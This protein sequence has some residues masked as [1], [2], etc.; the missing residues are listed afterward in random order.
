MIIPIKIE[1]KTFGSVKNIHY[2]SKVIMRKDKYKM[3]NE[4]IEK[5]YSAVLTLMN[6]VIEKDQNG[7][8][9][10]AYN[11]LMG[12]NLENVDDEIVVVDKKLDEL[13]ALYVE[14]KQ[15]LNK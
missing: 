6:A 7:Q 1:Y 4:T 5:C 11:L 12:G 9:S 10:D 3:K 2:I 15:I 8:T 14:L 13:E